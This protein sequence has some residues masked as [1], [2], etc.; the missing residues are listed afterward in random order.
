MS[1]PQEWQLQ[2]KINAATRDLAKNYEVHAIRSD[3]DRLE[4]TLRETRALVDGLRYELQ[5]LQ[6]TLVHVREGTQ[7]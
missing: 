3:V 6:E 5:A 4:H 7:P 2:D 1:Y